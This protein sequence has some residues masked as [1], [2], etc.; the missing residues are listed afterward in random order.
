MNTFASQQQ[1]NNNDQRN[2][3]VGQLCKSIVLGSSSGSSDVGGTKESLLQAMSEH[4][5][6]R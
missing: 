4:I 5:L 6:G 1:R 3:L 2:S